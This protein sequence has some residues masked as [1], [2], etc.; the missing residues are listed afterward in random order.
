MAIDIEHASEIIDV[1][2]VP[3]MVKPQDG[4]TPR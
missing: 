2:N 1:S 4:T 3:L